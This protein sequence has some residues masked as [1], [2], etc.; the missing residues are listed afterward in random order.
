MKP[1]GVAITV[2]KGRGLTVIEDGQDPEGRFIWVK[3]LNT[4][5]KIFG[6]CNVYAPCDERSKKQTWQR[7][8]AY[9]ETNIPWTIEGDFN[10][11]EDTADKLGGIPAHLKHV[12]LDWHDLRDL[13][14]LV[15]DPWVTNPAQ[16]K[17]GSLKYKGRMSMKMMPPGLPADWT[18]STSLS[19]LIVA[20][21]FSVPPQ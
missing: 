16:R 21:Y 7:M 6:I 12:S 5:G 10:F 18:G 9:L 2:R 19:Q 13:Q 14:L 15:C 4:D 11:V 17:K 20:G 1:G 8:Q 3:I